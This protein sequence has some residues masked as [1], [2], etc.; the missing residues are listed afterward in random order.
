MLQA[1]QREIDA[2]R[3]EKTQRLDRQRQEIGLAIGDDV[4][5]ERRIHRRET[6]VDH[7]QIDRVQALDRR[8]VVERRR[9]AQRDR[10]IRHPD[11][12]LAAVA[13]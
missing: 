13:G 10:R 3:R 6:P 12:D 7:R 4:V 2:R 8:R 11:L 9:Q 5:D 1:L